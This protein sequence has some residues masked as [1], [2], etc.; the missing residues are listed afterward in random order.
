MNCIKRTSI[1]NSSE[2]RFSIVPAEHFTED[3]P[4]NCPTCSCASSENAEFYDPS[5]AETCCGAGEAEYRVKFT[6]TLT[7]T[8]H[9]DY[10]MKSVRWSPLTGVSHD[11]SYEVWNACMNNVSPGVALVSLNG[12]VTTIQDEYTAQGN[13]V[14]DIIQGCSIFGN[15][16]TFN[17]FSVDASHPYVS[18]LKKVTI[19]ED[20]IIGVAGL[21]LCD[22][23]NWKN[24]VKVCAELFSTATIT[25]REAVRNSVQFNHCSFGYFEFRLVQTSGNT[26]SKSC[27]CQPR[28][29]KYA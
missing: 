10:Y 1:V 23:D 16:F 22:G 6:G 8:C 27:V 26:T 7:S 11:S 12:S 29:E 17:Q 18:L 28:G 15:S 19:S 14:K 3:P 4:Q 13:S 2:I 5:K 9:S 21:K 25:A 20:T 24:Y